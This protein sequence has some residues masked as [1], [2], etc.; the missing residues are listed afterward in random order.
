MQ[1]GRYLGLYAVSL[2]VFFLSV[3]ST[4]AASLYWVC[5]SAA[6]P[7]LLPIL[8]LVPALFFVL[9]AL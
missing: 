7:V 2:S 9:M 5:A 8:D 3:L 6:L 1:L 4:S